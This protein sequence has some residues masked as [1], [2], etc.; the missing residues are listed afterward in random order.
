MYLVDGMKISFIICF[1][2]NTYNKSLMILKNL[3]HH[4]I[5]IVAT[6]DLKA[7][8]VHVWLHVLATYSPT[9]PHELLQR[10]PSAFDALSMN[11]WIWRANK[12]FW[13][14]YG[15]VKES[16]CFQTIIRPPFIANYNLFW[17]HP[18]PYFREEYRL[19][20]AVYYTKPTLLLNTLATVCSLVC[21]K[22]PGLHMLCMPPYFIFLWW[23]QRLV[24]FNNG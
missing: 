20:S 14:I 8:L 22:C 7:V 10:I 11:L 2:L 19:R 1:M 4:L 23:Q 16:F 24:Y 13:M 17:I 9:R 5:N 21:A 18:L 3:L 15:V 6:I 12:L